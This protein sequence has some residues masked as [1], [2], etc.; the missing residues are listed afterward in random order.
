M[1]KL[2][3]NPKGFDVMKHSYS[4]GSDFKKCRRYYKLKRIDG[5]KEKTRAVA[6]EFGKALESALQ[7]YHVSNLKPGAMAEEF[8]RIWT[9]CKEIP[10]LEYKDDSWD[11]LAVMGADMGRLYEAVFPSLLLSDLKFQLNYEK[12]LYPGTYLAG[13]KHTAYLDIVAKQS[14][15]ADP[16]AKP[17]PIVVDVKTAGQSYDETPELHALDP[18][19]R[20]Y[21]WTSGIRNT[22]FLVFVKV[23]PSVKKGDTVTVVT[24]GTTAFGAAIVKAGDRLKI[25]SAG[26]QDELSHV[27]LT[28]D[29]Y[30]KYREAS[31]GLTGKAAV[32]VLET[33][34]SQGVS[35]PCSAVTKQR[36]QF[37]P[38]TVSLER[39]NDTGTI[40]GEQVAQ[41]VNAS[42][43]NAFPEDGGTIFPNAICTWCCMRGICTGND[44]LRDELIFRETE[45]DNWLDEL[46]D[47]D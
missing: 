30:E 25:L 45:K 6:F 20:A 19:L 47:G 41:I 7:F 34:L 33:H 40:I 39:A 1:A 27:V 10:N 29:L 21:S 9:K 12:E 28:S 18:Q 43:K 5:W 17:V 42:E 31:K 8:A 11:D 35:I 37:L 24:P 2:Y 13:I 16:G 32:A 44:K 3:T 26:K 4:A 46:T 38:A 15:L 22:A 36:L 14:F 23:S